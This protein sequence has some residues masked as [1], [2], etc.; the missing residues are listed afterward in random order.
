MMPLLRLKKTHWEVFTSDSPPAIPVLC[1][2]TLMPLRLRKKVCWVVLEAAGAPPPKPWHSAYSV[3]CR[4]SLANIHCLNLMHACL[5]Y[6]GFGTQLHAQWTARYGSATMS[7]SALCYLLQLYLWL[8]SF[9]ELFIFATCPTSFAKKSLNELLVTTRLISFL[10]SV[11]SL[12]SASLSRNHNAFSFSPP[13]AFAKTKHL[14]Q[15]HRLKLTQS[16]VSWAQCKLEPVIARQRFFF[17][18]FFKPFRAN[19][20][21][22][23]STSCHWWVYR[24]L[25]NSFHSR[26]TKRLMPKRS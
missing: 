12:N 6:Y 16:T 21:N 2:F 19:T 7:D 1:W 13:N 23:E 8:S 5:V 20:A 22:Y 14:F 11:K 9:S 25:G 17:D 10:T 15:M 18:W 4:V 24:G 3:H 26:K